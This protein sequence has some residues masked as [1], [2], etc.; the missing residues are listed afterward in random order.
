MGEK[1]AAK[2]DEKKEARGVRF[3]RESGPVSMRMVLKTGIGESKLEWNFQAQ[4]MVAAV[5]EGKRLCLT[6]GKKWMQD[7]IVWD[8]H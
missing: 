1:V 2:K 7:V 4:S 6:N 8:N 3:A 5:T